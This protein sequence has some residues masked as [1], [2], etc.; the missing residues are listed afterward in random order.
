MV[1]ICNK[2]CFADNFC[3]PFENKNRI[4][5][6]LLNKPEGFSCILISFALTLIT[7]LHTMTKFQH[8]LT[9]Y[10]ERLSCNFVYC[11]SNCTNW[12]TLERWLYKLL[13]SRA[14]YFSRCI[15]FFAWSFLRQISIAR[16][17]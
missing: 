5:I 10:F 12:D 1:D 14:T 7:A 17:V 11:H 16:V 4:T 8:R 3:N 6:N 15:Y 13:R 9:A 2:L